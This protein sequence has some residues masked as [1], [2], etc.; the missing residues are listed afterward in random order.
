MRIE[1][2]KTSKKLR[3]QT[4]RRAPVTK[5]PLASSFQ[6]NYQDI[7]QEHNAALMRERLEL[8][9][10][11]LDDLGRQLTKSFSVYDLVAYKR[12]LHGFLGEVQ[13]QIYGIKEETGWSGRGRPK[14]FQRIELL[15]QELEDLTTIV[16]EKQKDAVKLLRKLDHIRG[17]LIDLYS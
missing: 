8:L 9:L 14:I 15:N 2:K 10:Q 4:D 13:Q 16:L 11:S 5:S 1:N 6:Q 17:L 7:L 3:S 12:T